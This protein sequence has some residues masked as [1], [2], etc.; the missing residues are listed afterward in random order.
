MVGSTD[1][2]GGE[3]MSVTR[4]RLYWGLALLLMLAV[5]A[6]VAA[7][8]KQPSPTVDLSAVG[9][10]PRVPVSQVKQ[11]MAQGEKVVFLDSRSE[12]SWSDA[13]TKI[14]GSI[15]VP[16]NDVAPYVDKIPRTGRIIAYCT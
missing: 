7:C 8:Q 13:K 1:S 9:E 11:W 3:K 12:A 2:I 14:P 5:L 15:R 6:G 16:P 4:S 10:A